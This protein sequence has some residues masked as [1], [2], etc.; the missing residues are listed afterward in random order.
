MP[1]DASRPN[2]LQPLVPPPRL[3][4]PL[5]AQRQGLELLVAA[6]RLAFGWLDAAVAQQARATRLTLG[7]MTQ[8]AHLLAAAQAP[9]GQAQAM[10]DLLSEAGTE[11]VRTA[12]QLV[13]LASRMQDETLGLLDRLL[14]PRG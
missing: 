7:R 14:Q 9:A 8:A 1:R 10:L 11:G 5:A 3:A 12:E 4:D 13:A 6:N 2:H